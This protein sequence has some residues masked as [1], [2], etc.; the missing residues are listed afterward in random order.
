M[1]QLVK[2]LT[3]NFRSGHDLTVCGFEPH[4][5]LCPHC[6]EQFGIL[7]LSLSLS[8]SLPLLCLHTNSLSL[9]IN[10]HLKIHEQ[11]F[12]LTIRKFIPF[13]S[14]LY[15]IF[16]SQ[17]NFILICFVLESSL[18]FLSYLLLG[19]PYIQ[20]NFFKYPSVYSFMADSLSHNLHAVKFTLVSVYSSMN[21]DQYI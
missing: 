15:L 12:S 4:S 17:Q 10:K 14:L 5:G 20:M 21:F 2:H 16:P 18:L 1:A 7:S 11:N 19:R 6:M 8:L 13:F 3:L 9:K